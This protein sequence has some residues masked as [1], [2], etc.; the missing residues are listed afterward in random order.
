M[1]L[2]A[3]RSTGMSPSICGSKASAIRTKPH[4]SLTTVE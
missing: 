4:C 2:S 3:K 1:L